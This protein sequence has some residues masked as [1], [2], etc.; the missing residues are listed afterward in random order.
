[1]KRE[2]TQTAL[3]KHREI[4]LSEC[5]KVSLMRFEE[6]SAKEQRLVAHDVFS[7]IRESKDDPYRVYASVVSS[8][9]LMCTHPQS[10]RLY[11]GKFRYNVSPAA[12]KHRWYHCECCGSSTI[13]D[14]RVMFKKKPTRKTGV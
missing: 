1:M 13:N 9:G 2:K 11:D 5:G 6:L 8:W 3:E 14:V 7:S 10:K 12:D 4:F